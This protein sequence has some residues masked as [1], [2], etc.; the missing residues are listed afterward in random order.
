MILDVDYTSKF[1]RKDPSNIKNT[2]NH[3][4]IIQ[5][6]LNISKR[7]IASSIH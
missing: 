7:L 6:V 3:S 5:F 4:K 1:F 2:K